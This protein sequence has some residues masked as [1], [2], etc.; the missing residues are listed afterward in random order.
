MNASPDESRGPE[1]RKDLPEGPC[2]GLRLSKAY[3]NTCGGRGAGQ[4]L[5]L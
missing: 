4:N 1:K 3:I 5:C 2:N